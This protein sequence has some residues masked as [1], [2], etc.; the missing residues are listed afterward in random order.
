MGEHTHVSQ[1]DAIG[2]LMAIKS[3]LCISREGVDNMLTVFG[4]LPEGHIL[5]KSMYATQRLLKAL[6][7]PYEHIDACPNG[8]ILFRKE[9]ADAKHCP[10]CESSRYLEIDSRLY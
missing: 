7:M 2:R 5:A 4:R 8:C 6:K 10:K 1:L 9:H 3:Q